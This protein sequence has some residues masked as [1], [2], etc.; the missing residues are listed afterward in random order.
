MKA[1]AENDKCTLYNRHATF[2]YFGYANTVTFL[3]QQMGSI[4]NCKKKKKVLDEEAT[5]LYTEILGDHPPSSPTL[6]NLPTFGLILVF[7][8]FFFFI[9]YKFSPLRFWITKN[10]IK[11]NIIVKYKDKETNVLDENTLYSDPRTAEK[12]KHLIAYN[13]I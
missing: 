13:P 8:L 2:P 6:M 4:K 3:E 9:L 11:K 7:I 1:T 10:L 5:S 12:R